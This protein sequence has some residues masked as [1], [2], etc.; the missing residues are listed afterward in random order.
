MFA[1]VIGP[2]LMVALVVALIL[3]GDAWLFRRKASAAIR[4]LER[5]RPDDAH[6]TA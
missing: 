5:A 1:E 4:E 6:S 3:S 2:A